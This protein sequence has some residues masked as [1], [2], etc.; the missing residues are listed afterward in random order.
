MLGVIAT[1]FFVCA[2]LMAFWLL[3]TM[4]GFI[5]YWIGQDLKNKMEERKARKRGDVEAA[6]VEVSSE[7]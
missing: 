5:P 2:F 7:E 4:F 1:L 3:L 6:P